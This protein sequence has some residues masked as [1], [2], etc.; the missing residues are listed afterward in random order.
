MGALVS[1]QAFLSGFFGV[2]PHTPWGLTGSGLGT[3][4]PGP[5]LSTSSQCP[6]VSVQ[7][8]SRSGG[9]RPYSREPDVGVLW[10]APLSQSTDV[11]MRSNPS[12]DSSLTGGAGRARGCRPLGPRARGWPPMALSTWAVG[13]AASGQAWNR[14]RGAACSSLH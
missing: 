4:S 7:A 10:G 9:Q 12:P 2:Q 11:H 6:A 3:V 13:R 14:R 5:W 1:P 8:Q